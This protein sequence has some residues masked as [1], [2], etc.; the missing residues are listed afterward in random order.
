MGSTETT[1]HLDRGMFTRAERLIVESEGP[2]R[3]L[4]A[5]TF[6][7]ESG[8]C[9]L[10]LTSR[11]GE[12][13]M[14]PY[15]GQQVWSATFNGRN[16][17][18]QSMF[19][20]PIPTRDFLRTFGG[21]LQHCG[22]TGVGGPGPEDTHP[23]H[24]ELP[25]APYDKAYVVVGED[26]AGAYIGLGG[27]YQYTVAFGDNY[28]AEPLVK[29]HAGETTFDVTMTLTNLKRATQ[30]V[31]YLAHVNFRPVDHARLVYSAPVENVRVR[32]SIPDHIKPGPGYAEFLQ[33]LSRDPAKHHVLE[34]GMTYDPEG[35]FFIDYLADEQGWAHS[36]QVHPDGTAD[37]IAHNT[38]P[39]GHATRWISRT[40]D[41][42]AIAI[43][44]AGTAE[45]EGYHAEKEKGNVI[46]LGPGESTTM[47]LKIGSL[48]PDEAEAMKQHIQDIVTS[49]G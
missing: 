23:L 7:F 13:V 42:D 33:E 11:L 6:R 31:L 47:E 44:E 22:V 41:Q 28:L 15:Q 17:T 3:A 20:Q 8:V 26:E 16:L 4:S 2:D 12:L 49:G 37:Y 29:L 19:D 1:I 14:L 46:V 48:A 18:M 5:S 32:A 10:R 43:V 30:E 34:P 35:V 25:N 21:F 24:G 27:S 38:D 39:L 40:P 9:G 45:P 36:M